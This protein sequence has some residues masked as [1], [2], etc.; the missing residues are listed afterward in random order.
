MN[1]RLSAND[2]FYQT[3]WEGVSVFNGLRGEGNGN[4]DSRRVSL[5]VS[6]N[7]GNSKVKSRKRKT[8]IEDEAGRVSNED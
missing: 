4:W 2:I 5:S 6:M 3:G 8:G 7:F 1:V